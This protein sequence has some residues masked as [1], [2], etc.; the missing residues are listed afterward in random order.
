M[1]KPE[2]GDTIR[3]SSDDIVRCPYCNGHRIEFHGEDWICLDCDIIFANAD[4][5]TNRELQ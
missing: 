5:R 3:F 4:G 2:I 1:S